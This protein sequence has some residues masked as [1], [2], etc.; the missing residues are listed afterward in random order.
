VE[1][2]F[3]SEGGRAFCS[4]RGVSVKALAKR[5]GGL[6]KSLSENVKKKGVVRAGDGKVQDGGR[7]L[8]AERG[9]S[10]TGGEG[11]RTNSRKTLMK[12]SFSPKRSAGKS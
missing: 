4:F 10:G 1:S 11:E 12:A 5:E 7:S 6:R 2:V 8:L 3:S 9:E